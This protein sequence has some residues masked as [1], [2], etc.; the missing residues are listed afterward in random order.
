MGARLK[1]TDPFCRLQAEILL[2][3]LFHSMVETTE[4]ADV[5]VK[6]DCD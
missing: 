1:N 4:G 5:A 2:Q 6:V 3:V